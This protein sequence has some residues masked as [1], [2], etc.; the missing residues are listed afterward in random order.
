MG[1]RKGVALRD[2]LSDTF[3]RLRNGQTARRASVGVPHS[4]HVLAV[5][6]TLTAL[7][8]I[9]AVRV[10]PPAS[11]AAP[12]YPSLAVDLKYG[13][14]GS[15]AI[16]RLERVSRPSRRIYAGARSLPP[17]TGGLGEWLLS[18]PQG[19]LSGTEARRRNVG[20]EVLGQVF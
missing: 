16:V 12:P 10:V 13:P 18:T 5:L 2:P 8:Y 19:V 20:G 14:G 6:R 1:V 15:P 4:R 3:A 7:G 9:A 17:A 11:P